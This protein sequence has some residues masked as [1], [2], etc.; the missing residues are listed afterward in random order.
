MPQL[1]WQ[2]GEYAR[3]PGIVEGEQPDARRALDPPGDVCERTA[4]PAIA[5][6]EDDERLQGRGQAVMLLNSGVTSASMAS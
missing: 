1:G 4:E 2:G 5:V 6:I 3:G